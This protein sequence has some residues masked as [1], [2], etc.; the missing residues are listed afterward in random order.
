MGSPHWVRSSPNLCP[1]PELTLSGLEP[2]WRYQFRVR[3][4]N[5]LG[6]SQPSE[7][8]DPLTVTLQRSAATIPHFELELK[9]TTALENEQAEFVVKFSG[10]PIPKISWFKDG[11]EIFSSRRTRIVTE[12]GKSTLLIHQT[13]LNDEGEIKCTAT[14]RAGHISTRA[15]LNLEAAPRIRL[16]RQYEDGLLFEQDEAIRLKVSIAGKPVPNVTWLHDGEVIKSDDR[17]IIDA[18]DSGECSMRI[19]AAR[20]KDRG[21]Y[22]VKAVNKLGEDI[23][24]FLV[25]VTDR[26]SAPGKAKIAMTLGRS[27]TLSWSEPEDDG[28]CKIGTYIIEY[29]RIGWD[30]WLKAA[31]C[32]QP[33]TTLSELIE[34]SE[35]KFRVK[36]ENPYGVSDPSEESDVIFIP[37]PK[38]GIHAPP[39]RPDKSQSQREIHRGRTERRD[40]SEPAKRT[41]SLT[42]E[43]AIRDS[44]ANEFQTPPSRSASAHKL[45]LGP[46]PKPPRADSR[47]T[48][49][50][51]VFLHLEKPLEDDDL[52]VAPARPRT[53]R[54]KVQ[55]SPPEDEIKERHQTIIAPE[56]LPSPPVLT[57]QATLE[58][59]ERPYVLPIEKSP[60]P[61]PPIKIP[62]EETRLNKPTRPI[63]PREATEDEDDT[64]FRGSSEIMLVLY[65]DEDAS[66]GKR[67]PLVR[68]SSEGEAEEEDEDLL[69][70]PMSLSLPELFSANHQVVE[71]LREA[72]SSTELLHERAM[73]RFYK[74]VAVEEA[75]AA[76]KTDLGVVDKPKEGLD[77]ISGRLR[78]TRLKRRPSSGSP[79]GTQGKNKWTRR[80]SS[81]GQTSSQL[82]NLPPSLMLPAPQIIASDPN[83]HEEDPTE[84]L[85]PASPTLA[86]LHHWDDKNMPLV[87]EHHA[88]E[89]ILEP[90]EESFTRIEYRRD[91]KTPDREIAYDSIVADDYEESTDAESEPESDSS[92]DL[93]TLK[94]RILAQ[95]IMDEE[96]T[97][98]PRGRPILYVPPPDPEYRV[99]TIDTVPARPFYNV[100]PNN[101]NNNIQPKSILKKRTEEDPVPLNSF[102]RPIPP[103]K[104]IIERQEK[105]EVPVEPPVTLR[106]KSVTDL[107]DGAV[108][109]SNNNSNS[110][111]PVMSELD[112]DNASLL[113][114]AEVAKNRRRSN[115]KPVVEKKSSVEEK[116]DLEARQAV[117]DHYMEIVREYSLSHAVHP[118][119]YSKYS[120][121][122]S[123]GAITT[124]NNNKN[125]NVNDNNNNNKKENNKDSGI[126]PSLNIQTKI[127]NLTEKNKEEIGRRNNLTRV[128][129]VDSSSS[130]IPSANMVQENLRSSRGLSRNNEATIS[131]SRNIST[132]RM[133][134]SSKTRMPEVDKGPS[135][136]SSRTRKR[137]L[138]GNRDT[139]SRSSSKQ[140]GETRKISSRNSSR[141]RF[142]AVDVSPSDSET[143]QRVVGKKISRER[144]ER[145]R[146]NSRA[147]DRPDKSKLEASGV[148]SERLMAEAHINVRSSVSYVI[149]LIILMAAIY[150]YLFK[151]EL[152]AIPFIFLLIYRQ[153]EEDIRGWIPKWWKAKPRDN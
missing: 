104:P 49:S 55:H 111:A 56:K 73:E 122:T 90:S 87:P 113:N 74:A 153:V 60:S 53:K 103:E 81:E 108:A 109:I 144:P 86:S 64:K 43:E 97:Y 48:F 34:G 9:D 59:F 4:Q 15:K 80:R 69:P 151:N 82:R 98:H 95:P 35:Y 20:R 71:I 124:T 128:T 1:F 118:V 152:F 94:S 17:H 138:S 42:R 141:E 25:T 99:Q 75:E 28:G 41:R 68:S 91:V 6:I 19:P 132:E 112:S 137:D 105:K 40:Q 85:K 23:V 110:N 83:L 50:D 77:F 147:Y 26:P 145:F 76:K 102:G 62:K 70:P 67:N 116:E 150:L 72:V 84:V 10:L 11:F 115:Q 8:S 135:R 38:R 29:Y 21:E 129:T 136:S 52:P 45:V 36:A 63:L 100:S 89:F 142:K 146:R 79:V 149:D 31:T 107:S 119:N 126:I 27:V 33:T 22:T 65:P 123:N 57:R 46:P 120:S 148:I 114:A 96:D 16:P 143:S 78:S 47:V 54:D 106:K 101:N 24:S 134:S 44:H 125:N 32:R 39:L 2:G 117:V 3:A 7:L 5:S 88:E 13:A 92:E 12:N 139:G 37:D 133:R 140:R 130:S 18:A 131:R 30:V 127:A 58:T 66:P 93:R 121:N 61:L 51:T 14:N